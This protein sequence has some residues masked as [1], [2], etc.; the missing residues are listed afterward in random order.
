MKN[1]KIH[2]QAI[3]DSEKIGNGSTIWAFVHILKNAEIGENVNIADHCFI[4]NNVTIGDNCTL[5]CGIYLWDGIQLKNNVFIGPNVSFTND[6]F[7]RSKNTKYELRKT[8]IDEGA[9]IG[10]NA[11]IIAGTIIGRHA[12]VG[13]GAVVT[14]D[15]KDFQ[16]V[17]GNPAIPKGY[18]CICG[19]KLD[20]NN[21]EIVCECGHKYHFV[22]SNLELI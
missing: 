20:T 22:N 3:V 1:Y 9:S 4:E 2:P 17:Y 19:K 12:L 16:L 13:A 15:V 14:K 5:K 10:A 11:T 21:Q 6:L 7:P 8:L 18:V